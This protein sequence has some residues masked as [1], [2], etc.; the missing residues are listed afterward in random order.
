MTQQQMQSTE[1]SKPLFGADN[2][3]LVALVSVNLMVAVVY[4]MTRMVYFLEGLPMSAFYD[5]V[6]H[7]FMLSPY[8]QEAL[9]KPWTFL[10]YNWSHDQFWTLC[11]NL[12]W[13][14][15]FGTILQNQ[16][17]NKHLF[18]IYFYSGILGAIAFIAMGAGISFMGAELSIMALATAA[19]SLQPNYQLKLEG[20]G[21]IP[22]WILFTVYFVIQIATHIS[23]TPVF[24]LTLS[25]GG[26]AGVGYMYLLK[27]K[28]D[29][30]NWM[31]VIV[32]KCN[33]YMA[34]KEAQ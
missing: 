19:L 24:F 23:G 3:A 5:E 9:E 26:F 1:Q 7:H 11:G 31:H 25:V 28:I 22:V 4:G 8:Y 30:G 33:G 14:T 27:K 6:V 32:K 15:V 10:I 16:K 12:I 21:G 2:N 34:P 13:L 17:A 29:L 20:T 18:P